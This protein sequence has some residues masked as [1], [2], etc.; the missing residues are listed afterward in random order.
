[1]NVW[2]CS[3]V[4]QSYTFVYADPGHPGKTVVLTKDLGPTGAPISLPVGIHIGKMSLT[5]ACYNTCNFPL[6][7]FVE[8][9]TPPTPN[10]IETT[11]VT[12]D[13]ATCWARVYA[14]DLNTSSRDNCCDNLHYAV[15]DM[16][17]VDYY[18]KAYTDHLKLICGWANY[19]R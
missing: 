9:M 4:K 1:M 14:K 13:P 19:E 10:C 11:Q 2:D 5:D 16:D 12:V 7:V 17:S 18:R 8:D 15:A 3:D 6:V